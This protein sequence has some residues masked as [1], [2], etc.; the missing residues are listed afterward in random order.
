MGGLGARRRNWKLTDVYPKSLSL[1]FSLFSPFA[2]IL[3]GA[4][5]RGLKAGHGVAVV[6]RGVRE[7]R[8]P[9]ENSRVFRRLEFFF[10]FSFPGR[11]INTES[12][13][14]SSKAENNLK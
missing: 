14:K 3:I 13:T 5:S 12:S 9:P 1:V 2:G 7:T 4:G 11:Y 10:S 6:S 8:W